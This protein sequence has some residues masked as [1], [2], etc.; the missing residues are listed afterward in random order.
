MEKPDDPLNNKCYAS[1][2]RYDE[3]SQDWVVISPGRGKRPEAFKRERIHSD[4]LPKDCVFCNLSDQSKPVLVMA[5][6]QKISDG[7]L[8]ADWS[9]AVI[10][11][12]FPA[13]CPPAG[14]RIHKIHVGPVYH[15]M[16]AVGFCEVLITREHDKSIALLG[17]AA[18]KELLDAYHSRYI[19]LKGSRF[20]KYISIFHNHG[21][22]AGAS[23]PHPHSQIIT[24]PL[25]DVDLR[26]ALENSKKYYRRTKK[27]LGCEMIS[28]ETEAGVRIICENDDF[29]AVCPFASKVAFEVVV[30]PKNHS[31]YFE[32]ITESE[33][34]NL[35]DIFS[36]VLKKIY[37]G[38]NDPPYNFYLHT[39]PADGKDYCYY[40][41]HFTIRPKTATMAG[42]EMG[43]HME[44][45]TIV[46]EAA[47]EYLRAQ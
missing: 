3:V 6:G 29:V 14:S 43:A 36:K 18:I 10:P 26:G 17:S 28:W 13:F 4:M 25:I 30:T 20:V 8:P 47:A 2:L 1:Q 15:L 9:L 34:E 31:P 12:K 46:P 35:A 37:N 24:T 19:A 21:V 7:T 16:D 44:I 27:C 32:Q 39:A 22:E 11:N 33:K 5:K 38:L 45:S 42:F 40:H 23:Q 41:W